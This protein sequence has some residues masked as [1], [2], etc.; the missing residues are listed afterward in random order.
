MYVESINRKTVD[1]PS[2]RAGTEMQIVEDTRV[3]T[4]WGDGGV[5]GGL[6]WEIRFL[7]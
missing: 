7:V 4:G 3:D 6:N 2:T 5:E 1:E